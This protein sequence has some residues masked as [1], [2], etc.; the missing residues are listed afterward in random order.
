[1]GFVRRVSRP[2]GRIDSQHRRFAGWCY[3]GGARRNW[4]Y[5]W[6]VVGDSRCA[7]VGDY[8]LVEFGRERNEGEGVKR[9]W[10]SW[11]RW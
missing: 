3:G 7:E 10:G 9:P 5:A 1:L 8:G 4:W 11:V 2:T 6:C